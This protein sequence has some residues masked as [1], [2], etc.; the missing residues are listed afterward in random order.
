VPR[1]GRIL[2]RPEPRFQILY[3]QMISNPRHGSP[4]RLMAHQPTR[5]P[6]TQESSTRVHRPESVSEPFWEVWIPGQ[7][8]ATTLWHSKSFIVCLRRMLA[9]RSKPGAVRPAG[10][11][12]CGLCIRR[13]SVDPL[14]LTVSRPWMG[15]VSLDQP[16]QHR[17]TELRSEPIRKMPSRQSWWDCIRITKRSARGV[18]FY[19]RTSELFIHRP[20]HEGS[21]IRNASVRSGRSHPRGER[22]GHAWL[23]H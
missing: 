18:F 11:G 23:V 15:R 6:T 21:W 16:P 4:P 3:A 1:R 5:A 10:P 8:L 7:W 14:P 9:P 20:V 19:L 22:L 2:G 13:G 12:C 17:R